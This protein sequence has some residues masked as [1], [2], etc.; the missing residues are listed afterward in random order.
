MEDHS[1]GDQVMVRFYST[2]LLRTLDLNALVE[3]VFAEF[4]QP[5]R[6]VFEEMSADELALAGPTDKDGITCVRHRCFVY[7]CTGDDR[8]RV[9]SIEAEVE[10]RSV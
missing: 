2:R 9:E 1:R 5:G 8:R 6:V 3:A 10:R 4:P 7:A